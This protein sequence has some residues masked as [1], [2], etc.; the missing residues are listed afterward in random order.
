MSIKR[1]S[2]RDIPAAV[3]ARAV[4]EAQRRLQGVL[5]DPL[6]SR[7]QRHAA[8]QQQGVLRQWTAGTLT[9]DTARS[10]VPP[11]E[12]VTGV[13]PESSPGDAPSEPTEHTVTVQESLQI[14]ED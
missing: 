7:E 13:P 1:L 3:R 5:S 12:T 11:S 6:A 9:E 8:R 4:T 2:Y 14:R 10:S